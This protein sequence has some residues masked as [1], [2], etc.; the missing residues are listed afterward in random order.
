MSEGKISIPDNHR[1]LLL[2]LGLTE[3]DIRLI[4]GRL[5]SY[6]YDPE[7]GVRL[8]D[9]YYRTSYN[10]YI[11]VDGWSA[12]SSEGDTFMTN[13][14]KPA[15]EVVREIEANLEKPSDEQIQEELKKKFKK[16]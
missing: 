13:I 15:L 7:K 12:W 3:E 9:P 2:R 1:A 8:Y 5:V 16:V 6:E 11:D 14:L 4:D 10:E